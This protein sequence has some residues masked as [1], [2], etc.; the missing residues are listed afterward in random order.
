MEK[1]ETIRTWVNILWNSLELGDFSA[2][3]IAT[4]D[5][6]NKI[7]SVLRSVYEI[8]FAEGKK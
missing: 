2:E 8:G 7:Y 4:T 6:Y 1:D 5:K 3:D